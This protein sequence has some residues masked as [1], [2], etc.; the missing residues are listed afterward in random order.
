LAEERRP[1]AGGAVALRWLP[2][3]LLLLAVAGVVAVL[4]SVIGSEDGRDW[5]R[6]EVGGSPI[7]RLNVIFARLV[8]FI[9]GGAIA[10]AL[11]QRQRV[12]SNEE[13][14]ATSLKRHGI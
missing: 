13:Q 8:P 2:P 9:A 4:P 1:V 11:L 7:Y 10:L 3:V 5:Y 12:R 14:T 6:G